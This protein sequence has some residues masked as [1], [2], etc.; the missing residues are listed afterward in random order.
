MR[1]F[2]AEAVTGGPAPAQA[3]APP[4]DAHFE[5]LAQAVAVLCEE[6]SLDADIPA[7]D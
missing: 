6:A 2:L 4:R 5:R 7:A 3:P 1:V